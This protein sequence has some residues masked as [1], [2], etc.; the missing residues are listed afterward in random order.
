MHKIFVRVD[1]VLTRGF[2]DNN[3]KKN[4]IYRLQSIENKH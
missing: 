1:K 3:Y 2:T 4:L